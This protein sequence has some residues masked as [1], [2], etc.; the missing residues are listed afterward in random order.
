M[1][2]DTSQVGRIGE[3]AIVAYLV[4]NGYEVYHPLFGN[5]SCDLVVIKDSLLYRVECK[6]SNVMKGSACEVGLRQTRLEI[7]K[8]FD[9][10]KSDLI[11]CYLEPLDKV[12]ILKSSD[13]DG[14]STVN[15]K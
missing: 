5:T 15:L 14:R 8:K 3:S 1:S 4:K 11:A 6:A 7:N 12:V 13:Y 9:A 10:S 2:K